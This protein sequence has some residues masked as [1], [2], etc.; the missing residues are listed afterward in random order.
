MIPKVRLSGPFFMPSTFIQDKPYLA[1]EVYLL[2]KRLPVIY[3]DGT[4]NKENKTS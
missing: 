1:F 2:L 3:P 4:G